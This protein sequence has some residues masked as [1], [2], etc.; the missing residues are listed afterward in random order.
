MAATRA[1]AIETA[2]KTRTPKEHLTTRLVARFGDLLADGT[3]SRGTKLPPERELSKLFGVSRNS[4][5]Q[6]LKVLQVMGLVQQ[7]TGYGTYLSLEPSQILRE[8]MR[9]L[10]LVD[11]V[12]HAE[13][14]EMRFMMEPQLAAKAAERATLAHLM[15]MEACIE[16]M[17]QSGQDTAKLIEADVA[18]HRTVFRAAGNR[19]GETIY[20]VIHDS[21]MSNI[22][23][24]TGMANASYVANLHRPIY[25]AVFERNP[26]QARTAM[27][28][29]LMDAQKVIADAASSAPSGLG[30]KFRAIS[31]ISQD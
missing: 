29:H 25:R 2:K 5:R 15:E 26:E 14:L 1:S 12:S 16:R 21:L 30:S 17:E 22:M 7:R 27:F 10:L 24:T 23:R 9:F 13:L 6:A 11:P 28:Q 4:L 8:P 31:R 20:C 18:F 19:L 3:L